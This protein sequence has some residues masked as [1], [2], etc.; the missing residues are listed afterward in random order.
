MCDNCRTGLKV[1][2][3]NYTEEAILV[4]KMVQQL[5]MHRQNFTLK[6][7]VDVFKGRGVKS[8]YGINQELVDE[9]SGQLKHLSDLNLHRL[10]INL[11]IRGILEEL[12]ISTK[13]NKNNSN[14]SVYLILGKKY[15][16]VLNGK[17]V[18]EM[19]DGVTAEELRKQ[20]I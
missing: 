5:V 13:I 7:V 17:L 6:M 18:V 1:T 16:N 8:K 2:N 11:L 14:T 19:S 15:E 3:R 4:V 20:E 12:F 9:F 10:I